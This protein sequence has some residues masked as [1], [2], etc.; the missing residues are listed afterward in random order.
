MNTECHH[1]VDPP[2]LDVYDPDNIYVLEQWPV[3]AAFPRW[4]K[5]MS[6]CHVLCETD[7]LQVSH[8]LRTGRGTNHTCMFWL[9]ELFWICLVYNIVIYPVYIAS[10]DNVLADLLSRTKYP[11]YA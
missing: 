6:N 5:L 7:N 8:L 10:E 1:I 11:D 2:Q 4:G 3:V 9:R